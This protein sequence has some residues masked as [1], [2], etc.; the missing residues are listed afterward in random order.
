MYGAILSALGS[1]VATSIERKGV[2][3]AGSA[4]VRGTEQSRGE[5]QAG[6]DAML[7]RLQPYIAAGNQALGKYQGLAGLS[8]RE[9]Q[10]TAYDELASSPMFQALTR[11]GE[12]AMLQNASAT[13]GL[14]GGDVQGALMQYRPQM[15]NQ[16]VQQAL[17]QYGNLINTGFGAIGGAN[18]AEM[19]GRT[20]IAQGFMDEGAARAWKAM[21]TA[22][23]DSAGIR[24]F[25]NSM[26]G[27]AGGGGQAGGGMGGGLAGMFGGGM[28]G[29][30][31]GMQS[32]ELMQAS[33][34]RP[35]LNY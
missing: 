6:M 29:G 10:Q 3:R 14:R 25:T 30:G 27:M 19:F 20:G 13:G 21:Q 15:L 24:S 8:G 31:G 2:G 33:Q 35:Y 23:V 12:E 32:T 5:Y 9:A 16:Q 26:G 7:A 34:T 18:Q 11:Q 28:A 22:A 4:L 1:A 17:G